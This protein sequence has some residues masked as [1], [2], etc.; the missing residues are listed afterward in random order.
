MEITENFDLS[1]E[2]ENLL[3]MH[4]VLNVL[5]VVTYEL[6]ELHEAIG[7]PEE[8]DTAVEKV[9]GLAEQLKDREEALHQV[10][11]V[12]IFIHDLLSIL[13]MV[14]TG[15][16]TEDVSR[17]NRSRENL[18][19][20]FNI[21]RIRGKEIAARADN[22][23]AWVYHDIEKLK[24]NFFQVFKAIEMN[25]DGSY[26][27]VGNIARYEAGDYF[28]TFEIDSARGGSIY[29][30]AVFQDV[31]RDLI[32]NARKYT[33]PGGKIIA[34]LYQDDEEL[35]FVV[36]D[37]GRGIP[38]N[39]IRETIRFGIR[40]SNVKDRPTRGGGF[41]LTKAYYITKKQNGRM[42]I[43]KNEPKGTRIEIRIPLPE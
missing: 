14:E 25:S 21:L 22:P 40:G 15:K 42:W 20:I 11:N 13:D 5:N 9:I 1:M 8:L 4:S 6:V 43:E 19:S 35:R 23:H 26:H 31:V 34:G 24:K 17:I 29:M 2:E 32:A 38:E 12:E 37:T 41:G 18:L 33:P 10:E 28:L 36:A 27:I 39:E 7:G 16:T 3:D 30:P